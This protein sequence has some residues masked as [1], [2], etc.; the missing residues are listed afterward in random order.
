MS[1]AFV[2]GGTGFIGSHTVE[3]LINQGIHVRCLV[4]PNRKN[5]EWISGLPVETVT[6]DLLAPGTIADAVRDADYIIHIAGVT[7][8]KRRKDFFDGNVVAT[9]NLLEACA[10]ATGLKKFCFLSSLTATGPS[11]NGV[12]VDEDTACNPISAYGRSKLDAE[13]SCLSPGKP[14]PV[15][16]L[17]PPTVYGPRDKDVLE[18]F[19]AA[20]MGIQPNVG[21]TNK[22]LSLIYGPDLAEVIVKA[23]LT[24]KTDGKT[25]FV[26]DP[27]IYEQARMFGIVGDLVGSKSIR[28]KLPPFL[29]YSAAA[30][31]EALSYFGPRPALLSRDKARD[32][33]QDHWVC[34]PQRIKQDIAFE[35]RTNAE[36]GLKATYEWYKEKKWI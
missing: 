23:T 9:R 28:I 11:P 31:V 5:L 19:R 15:V 17:R 3:Q 16:I 4:R 36:M 32:M 14:F 26:S 6:G 34:N 30:L 13:R 2:T 20:K 29:V 8:A 24:D 25:Y 12:P 18:V 33:A 21:S 27:A 7:R 10:K 35:T 22:T 1:I